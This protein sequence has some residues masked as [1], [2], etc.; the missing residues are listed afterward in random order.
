MILKIKSILT[1][2]LISM[3]LISCSAMRGKMPNEKL[4]SAKKIVV[5]S[6][7]GD[8]FHG[9]HI[10][11]TVFNN[12]VYDAPVPEWKIDA[13]NEQTL[14]EHISKNNTRNVSVLKHDSG[15][16]DRFEKSF[17]FLNDGFSYEEIINLAK[18]Q[19]ADTVILI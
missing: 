12:E 3:L 8:T 18:Q 6:L 13:F 2:F 16:G 19:G 9:I 7:L 5:V 17:S 14:I 4:E 15:L 1:I 11:G 10:G